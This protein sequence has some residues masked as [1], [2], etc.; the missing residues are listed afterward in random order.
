M[1]TSD[2]VVTLVVT[3]II[4]LLLELLVWPVFIMWAWNA[5]MPYLLGLPMLNWG[6]AFALNLLCTLLFGHVT[7]GSS[8]KN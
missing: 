7:S 3:F 4:V 8:N 2:T 1:R 6:Y 5:V